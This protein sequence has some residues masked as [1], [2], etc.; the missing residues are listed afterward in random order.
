MG[1]SAVR[2]VSALAFLF[3]AADIA[4]GTQRELANRGRA[5]T[6]LFSVS[7]MSQLSSL[8]GRDDVSVLG[9]KPGSLAQGIASKLLPFTAV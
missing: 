2:R 5:K 1:L 8:A 6:Q 7:D 3:V 4:P 9:I